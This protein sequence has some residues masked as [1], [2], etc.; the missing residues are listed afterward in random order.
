MNTPTSLILS[1]SIFEWNQWRKENPDV[2]PNLSGVDLTKQDLRNINLSSTILLR[3]NLTCV[4]LSNANCRNANFEGANLTEA[5][6]DDSNFSKANMAGINLAKSHINNTDFSGV[7]LSHSNL[8]KAELIECYLIKANLKLAILQE[9]NLNNSYLT[10]ANLMDA[11]LV[12]SNLTNVDLSNANVVGANFAKAD[13]TGVTIE[14]WMI[15]RTTKLDQVYCNYFYCQSR[16]KIINDNG[17]LVN[18]EVLISKVNQENVI[19]VEN[20]VPDYRYTPALLNKNIPY[21][22]KNNKQFNPKKEYLDSSI[23]RLQSRWKNHQ[24]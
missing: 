18:F 14:D 8:T 16:Q 11:K 22:Q 6:V 24:N 12:Q 20:N 9:T 5:I 13:L 19:Q 2:I 10:Q 15:D 1:N 17:N 3:A 4:N 21:N 7:D 23:Q